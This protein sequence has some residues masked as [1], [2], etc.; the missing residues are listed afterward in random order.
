MKVGLLLTAA[1]PGQRLGMDVPKGLVEIAG[2]PMFLRAL[3]R[4]VGLESI[5]S[6]VIVAPPGHVDTF[7]G[8][9]SG[10]FPDM[11]VSVI[12]GGVERQRSVEIGL[13]AFDNATELV[14]IH[15]AARPFVQEE[16]IREVI[17]A[18]AAMGAAT[19]A[20]PCVDTILVDDGDAMLSGTPDRSGLWACQTPQVF[21]LEIVRAAHKRALELGE[22]Y[23][24]DATLVHAAGH[25]VRIVAS[26][27]DN[28]KITTPS[29][30]AFAEYLIR[31]G[32]R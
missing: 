17:E 16:S 9:A 25:D 4:F 21:A 29:D 5:E 26:S 31:E 3:G 22:M 24:D 8:L 18:A 10:D 15:D 23:T 12:Q 7:Q 27:A 11:P 2:V 20:T 32:T 19:L 30:L 28:I 6:A 14:A 13:E 1:G